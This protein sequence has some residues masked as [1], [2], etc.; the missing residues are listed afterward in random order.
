MS[1]IEEGRLPDVAFPRLW[2]DIAKDRGAEFDAD[3]S[4]SGAALAEV[5]IAILNGCP[6]CRAV[7][8]PYNSYQV[9]AD[10]PYSYCADCAGVDR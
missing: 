1:N 9:A 8:A 4:I 10:N 3:G 2:L 5:G 6:G 7:V